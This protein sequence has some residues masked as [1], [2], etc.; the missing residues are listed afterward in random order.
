MDA[1]EEYEGPVVGL[2][3]IQIG[4]QDQIQE[5]L[6]EVE[7]AVVGGYVCPRSMLFAEDIPLV[8]F[9]HCSTHDDA[10]CEAQIR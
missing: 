7:A 5:R 2:S 8:C 6:D 10:N 3:E 1:V 9:R 4:A